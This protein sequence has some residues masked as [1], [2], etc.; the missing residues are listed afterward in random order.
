MN[1]ATTQ[2][3]QDSLLARFWASHQVWIE[4]QPRQISATRSLLSVFQDLS[5]HGVSAEQFPSR[6]AKVSAELFGDPKALGIGT[7]LKFVRNNGEVQMSV[8]V[9]SAVVGSPTMGPEY[10]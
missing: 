5:G 3:A 8:S 10:A 4:D 9:G 7:L 1:S 6:L 2:V